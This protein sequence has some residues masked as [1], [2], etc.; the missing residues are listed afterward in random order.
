MRLF[1]VVHDAE[2]QK[3]IVIINVRYGNLLSN[4]LIKML[5]R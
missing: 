4:I 5:E 2:R 1:P 3:I